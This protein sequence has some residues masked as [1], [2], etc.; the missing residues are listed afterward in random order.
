MYRDISSEGNVY[1]EVSKNNKVIYHINQNLFEVFRTNPQI[2]Q[3]NGLYIKMSNVKTYIY[4][5]TKTLF[6]STDEKKSYNKDAFL[7]TNQRKSI[8][9]PMVT[10]IQDAQSKRE[11]TM[12]TP[13]Q[14]DHQTPEIKFNKELKTPTSNDSIDISL[15]GVAE[16]KG[17]STDVARNLFDTNDEQIGEPKQSSKNKLSNI[18]T[19]GKFKDLLRSS[20]QDISQ[21][22]KKIGTRKKVELKTPSKEIPEIIVQK[23]EEKTPRQSDIKFK[24][25]PEPGRKK[26]DSSGSEDYIFNENN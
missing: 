26:S 1:L 9:S 18:V 5:D 12:L 3:I 19:S 21:R 14:V 11:L 2:D 6:F 15:T 4:D 8:P 13:L 24:I 23:D 25:H 16:E 10:P 22:L 17:V 7:P 20:R